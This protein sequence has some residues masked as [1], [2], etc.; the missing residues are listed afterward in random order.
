MIE[1]IAAWHKLGISSLTQVVNDRRGS[2]MTQV[3]ND[4][5][6]SSMAQVGNK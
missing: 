3:G 2:S 6:D 5:S 4:G 1:V